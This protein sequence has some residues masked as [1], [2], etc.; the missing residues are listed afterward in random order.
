MTKDILEAL[1]KLL[2][3]ARMGDGEFD[4][5][6]MGN[7]DELENNYQIIKQAL[8]YIKHI[9]DLDPKNSIAKSLAFENIKK[10]IDGSNTDVK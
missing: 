9:T 3:L 7:I 8:E 1:D 2:H 5:N 10:I 4:K 6:P